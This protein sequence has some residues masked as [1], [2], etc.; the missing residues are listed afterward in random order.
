MARSI[1]RFRSHGSGRFVREAFGSLGDN[2]VIEDGV[3]IFDE[4]RVFIGDNVYVGHDSHLVGYHSGRLSIGR[5][6][7]IGPG[8]Y[9]HA[10]GGVE[11]GERVGVGAG[12]KILTS[13]HMEEGRRQPILYSDLLMSPVSIGDD[14]D[15][16]VGAIILPGVRIGVGVQV[17]AGAVVSRDVE[18]YVVVAGVPA[19][20]LRN[21]SE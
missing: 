10:A 15:I 9:L 13:S 5:D 19:R 18:D 7:W 2:V 21:R 20:K 6:S 11:I 16:G 14:S 17:G 1:R 8:V 4:S 12:V 3:R